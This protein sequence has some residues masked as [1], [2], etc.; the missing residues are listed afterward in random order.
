MS[1]RSGGE[2][3]EN[4]AARTNRLAEIRRMIDE[5]T[6]E[7]DERWEGAME[8]LLVEVDDCV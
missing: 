4:N 2:T 3:P 1:R 6:Y 8:R 7:T 5:G